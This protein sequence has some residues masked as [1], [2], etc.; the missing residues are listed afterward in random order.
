MDIAFSP[1]DEAFREEVRGFIAEART[2]LP[3]KLGPPEQA[4][5]SRDDY[6]AWHKLL[7]ARGWVAPA[8]PKEH[9]GAGWSVTRRYIFQQET[10]A[11]DMPNTPAFRPG[12][13]GLR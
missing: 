1:E 8:W 9:G 13:G 5:R 2:R 11:A 3:E 6:M 7:Y 10:A 4:N 12:H